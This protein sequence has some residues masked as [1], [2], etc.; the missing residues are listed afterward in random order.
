MFITVITAAL[1]W[2]LHDVAYIIATKIAKKSFEGKDKGENHI[3]H[4]FIH[5]WIHYECVKVLVVFGIQP[6]IRS[7]IESWSPELHAV[8][9]Y[10]TS[11]TENSQYKV[12]A[13]EVLDT[14]FDHTDH[15]GYFSKVNIAGKQKF[16]HDPN[17]ILNLVILSYLRQLQQ[18]FYEV[19][20]TVKQRDWNEYGR[21]FGTSKMTKDL[22]NLGMSKPNSRDRVLITDVS[23]FK[24][25]ED[26]KDVITSL[27]EWAGRFLN[28]HITELNQETKTRLQRTE[29][30]STFDTFMLNTTDYSTTSS[31]KSAS[32]QPITTI[33]L[34]VSPIKYKKK[35]TNSLMLAL[36]GF[37]TTSI[38]AIETKQS[39]G[40]RRLTSEQ[41]NNYESTSEAAS[42][43]IALVNKVD[44]TQCESLDEIDTHLTKKL[45]TDYTK[46][47]NSADNNSSD[48]SE[49]SS[50]EEEGNTEIDDDNSS[51]EE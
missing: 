47:D 2:Y 10:F 43:F 50:G 45:K 21:Y 30:P 22:K 51:K 32:K 33:K 15:N 42:N 1:S 6:T 35:S 38:A 25:N 23:Y 9:T 18:L 19:G 40:K 12:K 11:K 37:F 31:T 36:N 44:H 26:R 20:D 16:N 49:S 27:E 34:D 3:F 46:K 8:F 5:Y 13:F 7:D 4:Q 24:P 28:P 17:P 41:I 29:Q 48:D 14:L 39:S